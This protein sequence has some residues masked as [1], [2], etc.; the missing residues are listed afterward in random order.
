MG[1][2]GK[3]P[4]G[5]FVPISKIYVKSGAGRHKI[6]TFFLGK[7][8]GSKKKKGEDGDEEVLKIFNI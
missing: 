8:D 5:S 4:G 2:V 1:G 6:I 3:K 7:A